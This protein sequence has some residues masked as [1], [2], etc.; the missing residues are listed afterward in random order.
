MI[1]IK[2][3]IATCKTKAKKE[4]NSGRLY[5]LALVIVFKKYSSGKLLF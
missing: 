2:F 4:L 1:I 5:L 3:E